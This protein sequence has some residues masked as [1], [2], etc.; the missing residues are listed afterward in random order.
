MLASLTEMKK[1]QKLGNTYKYNF[2]IMDVITMG[3]ITFKE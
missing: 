1:N 3:K 2:P